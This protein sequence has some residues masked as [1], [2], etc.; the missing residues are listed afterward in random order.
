MPI[1]TC[2][3]MIVKKMLR[4]II[5]IQRGLVDFEEMALQI[6]FTALNLLSREEFTTG[7]P[8]NVLLDKSHKETTTKVRDGLNTG[9][10][11]NKYLFI[12]GTNRKTSRS[13]LTPPGCQIIDPAEQFIPERKQPEIH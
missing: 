6:T 13:T 2:E 1:L 9:M 11:F 3:G 5:L 7:D 12:I 10:V 8:T 4:M